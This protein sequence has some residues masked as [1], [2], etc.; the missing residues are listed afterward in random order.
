MLGSWGRIT[1]ITAASISSGGMFD[2][3]DLD[4]KED[5]CVRA[6]GL[7]EARRMSASVSVAGGARI[8]SDG[9]GTASW[10]P[11][12]L[13]SPCWS[14]RSR[15][16]IGNTVTTERALYSGVWFDTTEGHLKQTDDRIL[17]LEFHHFTPMIM[18]ASSW[19]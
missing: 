18:G 6:Q 9:T 16:T 11:P 15:R 8:P 12:L 17:E 14:R 13:P 4:D 7:A 10:P 3:D 19:S 5:D 1:E 2:F